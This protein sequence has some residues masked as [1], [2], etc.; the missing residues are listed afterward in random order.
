VTPASASVETSGAA[1]LGKRSSFEAA[2]QQPQPQHPGDAAT[3]SAAATEAHTEAESH[4]SKRRKTL[5][6]A[7]VVAAAA[8]VSHAYVAS[9]PSQVA[10]AAAAPVVAPS[11]AAAPVAG[12]RAR[13][14]I[15]GI[16]GRPSLVAVPAAKEK[17]NSHPRRSVMTVS[18]MSGSGASAA[19]S[20]PAAATAVVVRAPFADRRGH[21]NAIVAPASASSSSSSAAGSSASQDDGRKRTHLQ[22]RGATAAAKEMLDEMD[23]LAAMLAQHNKKVQ[24]V[25][26]YVPP[27]HSVK[28]IRQWEKETGFKWHDLS[29]MQRQ[30]ANEAIATKKAAQEHECAV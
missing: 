2:Q 8:A 1:T 29:S 15:S 16:K 11:A 6:A 7:D 30:E 25:G 10:A 13:A 26:V 9:G 5:D 23:D 17:E 21:A 14:S 27:M 20:K 19:V 12:S 24:P 28:E 18:G 22:L 3:A 4:D